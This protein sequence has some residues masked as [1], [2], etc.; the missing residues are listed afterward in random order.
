MSSQTT[1]AKVTLATVA[2]AVGVSL[3]TASNAYNHPERMSPA[4]RNRVLET[5]RRL[6]YDGPNPMARSLR[7]GDVGAVGLVVT[8][9]LGHAV[10]DPATLPFLQGLATELERA[11]LGLVLIPSVAAPDARL[12]A[13]AIVDGFIVYS[14]A[15]DDVLLEAALRRDLPLVLV[16]QSR[17]SGHAYVGLDQAGGASACARH[18]L[19]L[20]HRHFGILSLPAQRQATE[21]PIGDLAAWHIE[22]D[23][24]RQRLDGYLDALASV[25]IAPSAVAVYQGTSTEYVGTA[26]AQWLA[27]QSPRPTAILAMSDVLAVGAITGLRSLG[28][29]IPDD[30]S[31]TGFDDIALAAGFDPPL[32]SVRQPL[33]EKG[34]AAARL[35]IERLTNPSGEVLLSTELVVRS[36]TGPARA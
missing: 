33:R 32:T 10:S 1:R 30:V 23:V 15:R 5:A 19:E 35:F 18:L 6:G 21:G 17:I 11:R 28:L 26:G 3:S 31:V 20:G 27:Q 8:D 25:G 12:V 7:G 36:S 4:V 16:E 34:A 24:V 2:Q 13:Q 9:T 22:S 29:T 14:L